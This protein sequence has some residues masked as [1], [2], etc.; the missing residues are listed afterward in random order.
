MATTI[1]YS[2]PSATA[3]VTMDGTAG[4]VEKITVDDKY[5]RCTI[6]FRESDG[7]TTES[8]WFEFTGTDENAKTTAAFPVEAGGAYKLDLSRTQA[9]GTSV[10]YLAADSN[11][12]LAYLHLEV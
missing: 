9:K 6:T 1:A 3:R 4:N 10:F 8:G 12:A 11:S 2:G 7:T 5:R